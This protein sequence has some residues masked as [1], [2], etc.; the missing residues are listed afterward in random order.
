MDLSGQLH[1]LI[2]LLL[3]KKPTV[4]I[5][6]GWMVPTAGIELCFLRHPAYNLVTM[7]GMQYH[8]PEVYNELSV[9]WS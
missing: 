4:P 9:S 8:L 6:G 5:E 7:L 1:A 2:V 3:W